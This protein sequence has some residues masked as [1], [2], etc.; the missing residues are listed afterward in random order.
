[1]LGPELKK[2]LEKQQ[3]VFTGEHSAVKICTWTKK[4]LRDEDVCYKEKFYGIRSHL[5]CQMSPAIGFCHNRCIFCWR[6][7]EFT[8]GMKI[9]NGDNPIDII[10]KSIAAQRKQLSGFGG[11][12][13]VN[14]KKLKEAQ[15]PK[16]FA[17]SLSGEPLIYPK[18]NKLIKEL[19]KREISTF[20]VSNGMLPERLRRLEPPTQL[21]VSVDAPNETLFRKIDQSCFNDGWKRLNKSL[22][23][24]S[25]IK[26]RTVLRITLIKGLNMAD[27]NG[28]AKLIKKSK[29]MFVEVKAYMFVGY[30]RQRLEI[31]NMPRHH[32][33]KKFAQRIAKLSGYNIIDE[34][35]E[36]RVVLLAKRDYKKRIMRF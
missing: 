14:R 20:V 29:A 27:E 34:K 22:E 9:K 26:T 32:E 5:C 35:K 31:G 12:A 1:M 10:E 13:K 16:H 8:V 3:Y 36:S 2:L 15:S 33:V 4:S 7:I 25:K 19:H 11:N 28:Y 24:L 18:L 21:Y 23:L 30:S 17:I 6:P